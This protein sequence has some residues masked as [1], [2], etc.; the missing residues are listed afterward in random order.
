MMPTCG[1]RFVAGSEGSSAV[2]TVL[3]GMREGLVVARRAGGM[4]MVLDMEGKE[5]V[6]LM[7]ELG[8]AVEGRAK[9]EG[10]WTRITVPRK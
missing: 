1:S 4:M 7:V 5:D 9:Y 3:G 10:F 2:W 6:G 8:M